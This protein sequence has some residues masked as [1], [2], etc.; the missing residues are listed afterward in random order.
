MPTSAAIS[1]A[2]LFNNHAQERDE[3]EEC[4]VLAR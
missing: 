4:D 2:K 1:F 3:R